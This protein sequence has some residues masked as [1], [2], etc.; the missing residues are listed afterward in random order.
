MPERKVGE[1][2]SKIDWSL[3]TRFFVHIYCGESWILRHSC[4]YTRARSDHAQI[5]DYN[6]GTHCECMTNDGLYKM[7]LMWD[8]SVVGL[9]NF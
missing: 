2:K 8:Y 9:V 6:D 4:T 5:Q 7:S 1:N 3:E